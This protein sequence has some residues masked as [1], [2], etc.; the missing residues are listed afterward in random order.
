MLD[1]TDLRQLSRGEIIRD[2]IATVAFCAFWP[3]L[4]W[5]VAGVM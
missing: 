1:L 5:C 4:A 2:V 3:L